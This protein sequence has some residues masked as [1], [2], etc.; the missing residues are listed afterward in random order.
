MYNRIPFPGKILSEYLACFPA[1]QSLNLF[2]MQA[3]AK[4]DAQAAQQFLRQPAKTYHRR[5][6]CPSCEAASSSCKANGGD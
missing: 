6:K 3:G 5:S 2:V 1:A 4:S